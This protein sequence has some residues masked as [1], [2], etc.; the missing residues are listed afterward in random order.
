M[1]SSR[2]NREGWTWVVGRG[3]SALVVRLMV[4]PLVGLDFTS[5]IIF[6]LDASYMLNFHHGGFYK[7]VTT[8]LLA[9]TSHKY[10]VGFSK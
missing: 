2:R 1:R 10:G 9:L 8:E 6:W 3:T 5:S 7:V 4:M